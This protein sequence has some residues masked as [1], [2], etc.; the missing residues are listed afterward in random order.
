[1]MLTAR[2][3]SL[4]A[5][6]LVLKNYVNYTSPIFPIGYIFKLILIHK[7]AV[8]MNHFKKNGSCTVIYFLHYNFG[9]TMEVCH[10]MWIS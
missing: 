2:C 1:M 8:C 4:S 6:A 9:I 5:F 10:V 7:Y 3:A